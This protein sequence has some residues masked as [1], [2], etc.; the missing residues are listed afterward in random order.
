MREKLKLKRYLDDIELVALNNAPV[1]A[2][3]FQGELDTELFSDAYRLLSVRYPVL[4]ACIEHQEQGYLLHVPSTGCQNV[5]VRSWFKDSLEEIVGEPWNP[6]HGVA[7]LS[8]MK[9]E[10]RGLV[11]MRMDHSIV[12]GRGWLTLFAELWRIYAELLTGVDVRAEEGELPTAPSELFLQRFGAIPSRPSPGPAGVPERS[13]VLPG[14]HTRLTKEET[15][16]LIHA[17]H[18]HGTSVHALICGAILTSQ[19][20]HAMDALGSLAPMLMTCLSP[21][22]FR[23]LVDPPVS[24]LET[25]NFLSLHKA[26]VKVSANS[27]PLSVACEIKSQL[28]SAVTKREFPSLESMQVNG[29]VDARLAIALVS[30]AGVVPAFSSPRDLVIT[31][32][33]LLSGS[34]TAM[35]PA[36]GVYT[37]NSELNIRHV[38]SS[39]FFSQEEVER[40]AAITKEKL[41]HLMG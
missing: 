29:V 7:T 16:K 35:F 25:S 11:A 17:S 27:D 30:N 8:V 2:V 20:L 9:G 5:V 23:N 39:K 19:Y 22:D 1:F 41:F 28:D 26:D 36:H 38:Y 31:D 12:D 21:V 33:Q 6:V 32:F 4:R 24:P 18:K 34:D 37:Y 13:A 40:L 10:G 3:E 14:A 15:D